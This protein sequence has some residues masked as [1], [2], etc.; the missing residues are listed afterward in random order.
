MTKSTSPKIPIIIVESHHHVLEHIH[1]LLRRQKPLLNSWSLLHWD[2]HPDLACP[3][4]PAK[5][6]FRPHDTLHDHETLYD[7]LDATPSGIAEWI[8]PLVLAA[9]LQHIQWIRP[10]QTSMQQLPDGDFTLQ[11]GA[12]SPT[13]NTHVESFLDLPHDALLK[14]SWSVPYYQDDDDVRL[15]L[16][17]PQ[18][19]Q[20][21]VSPV[22]YQ[23][24]LQPIY[25][26]DVCLDYFYCHNPFVEDKQ[27]ARLLHRSIPCRNY[28]NPTSSDHIQWM[29]RFQ[30][31]WNDI[32][33]RPESQE[34][35]MKM[36][37]FFEEKEDVVELVTVIQQ[38]CIDGKALP[39]DLANI[40][41]MPHDGCNSNCMTERLHHF[42]K[43]L[44][45]AC[46]FFISVAR[47]SLEG[48]TPASVTEDL[49]EFVLN[50]LHE[51]YCGCRSPMGADHCRFQ[52]VR[53]Y[54]EW[55]GST[56]SN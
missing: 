33:A 18:E 23:E 30:S 52:L 36:A 14:V 34:H 54:G 4:C 11:V 25:G 24:R 20:L 26:L 17:L 15:E 38:H 8:L 29:Q 6:C 37:A 56:F 21:L 28:G 3:R 16:L 45:V 51:K 40:L 53:D 32:I 35:M 22:P 1:F 27:L 5:H 10:L 42:S 39:N 7:A 12:W 55:E 50:I 13:D 31:C 49:Q 9:R 41:T 2:A 47:S 48:F 19:L 44:P 46:P 43:Y